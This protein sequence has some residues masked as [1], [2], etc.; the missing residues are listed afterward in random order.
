MRLTPLFARRK[1]AARA[2]AV[3]AHRAVEALESRTL[4]NATLIGTP[5]P[6]QL[7]PG[8]AGTPIDLTQYFADPSVTGTV[9]GIDTT[10]GFIPVELFDQTAPKTVHNFL[11]YSA[12][13]DYDGTVIQRAVPGFIMQGGGYAVDQVH[14][15]TTT[16]IKNEFSL[17]N[18]VGTIA[19]S[20]NVDPTTHV[21]DPDSATTDWFI[22]VANNTSLDTQ[23]YTVF[24]HVLYNGMDPVNHIVNDLPKGAVAPTFE[25]N[26]NA[27]DPSDGVLPLQSYNVGS[28]IRPA[29][30]VL[31]NSVAPIL[32]LSYTVQSD[33]P[34]IAGGSVTGNTLNL[35]AGQTSGVAHVTIT[36][37][38]LGGNKVSSVIDVQV[39][40]TQVTIG[41]GAAKLVRFTDPD[42]TQAQVVLAGPG[43]AT[44]SFGGLGLTT[45]PGKGGIITLGGTPANV[46]VAATGT[47]A[48]TTLTITGTGGGNGTVDLAGITSDGALRA[49]NG[50]NT[51]VAGVVNAAGAIA[52]TTLAGV[53]GG[54]IN[55][56]AGAAA[57]VTV[58]AVT[59]SYVVSAGAF[60]SVAANTWAGGGTLGATSV[61]RFAV[62]GDFVGAIQVASLKTFT[63]GTITGGTCSVTGS[64][65]SLSAQS[66]SSWSTLLGAIGKVTIR[67]AVDASSIRVAGNITSFAAAALTAS[68]LFAG[69]GSANLPT[70]PTDFT[71]DANIKSAKITG[72]FAGSSIAAQE[73]TRIA[74]GPTPS[75]NGGSLFGVAA[76]R[77]AGLTANIDGKPLKLVNV[78]AQD[79]VTAAVTAAGIT[80]NDLA[81]RII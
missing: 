38:D 69:I 65:G 47:G 53:T 33:N 73:I 43:T 77:I 81:I 55:M 78:S 4:F 18:T 64:L 13:H 24:G 61:G 66:I 34:A 21:V 11:Q 72:S 40:Q 71:A 1:P 30:Y 20:L 51:V 70:I 56:G 9:V 58:G 16:P 7:V 68:K 48:G 54:G 75:T 36:A 49:I 12:I 62:K 25:P 6:V 44:V 79:Q 8:T 17:S 14:I 37:T 57:S 39:G 46:F 3:A 31:V 5:A 41:Q 50:K 45:T 26:V 23:K 76:H 67:G 74:L 32:P 10:Q 15:G 80:P 60:K 2:A 22:N 35:S 27:G 28:P 52:N 42:G 19:M 29:N 63:A 59:S